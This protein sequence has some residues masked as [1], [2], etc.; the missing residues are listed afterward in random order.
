VNGPVILPRN[1]E[2]SL[3]VL[4]VLPNPPVGV[5]MPFGCED[6]GVC[7]TDEQVLMMKDWINQGARDN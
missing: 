7:L 1:A 2:E 6:A 3:I 5:R 4:K